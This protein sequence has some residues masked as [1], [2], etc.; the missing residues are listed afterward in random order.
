MTLET[1]LNLLWL[2]VALG[3]WVFSCR[4]V[5]GFGRG[6][7]LAVL[8][9]VVCLFPCVSASDDL[10]KVGPLGRQLQV[11]EFAQVAAAFVLVLAWCFLALVVL[12]HFS[13]FSESRPLPAGRSPPLLSPAA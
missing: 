9:V 2:L 13:G 8:L 3:T 10:A 6:H 12:S 1:T 11:L 5:R 7:R 4:Q